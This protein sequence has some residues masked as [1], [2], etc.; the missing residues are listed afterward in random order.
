MMTQIKDTPHDCFTIIS[1]NIKLVKKIKEEE[2][3]D[4]VGIWIFSSSNM[5][6]MS[7]FS[8]VYI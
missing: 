7:V 6:Y 2:K 3:K 1:L 5:G 8:V 4:S